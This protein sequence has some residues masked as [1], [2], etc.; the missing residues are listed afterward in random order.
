VKKV[1]RLTKIFMLVLAVALVGSVLALP[2]AASEDV[3]EPIASDDHL[4]PHMSP[5]NSGRGAAL[6]LEGYTHGTDFREA[7]A[8]HGDVRIPRL[9]VPTPDMEIREVAEA[10]ESETT[11][12]PA[13]NTGYASSPVWIFT[14]GALLAAALLIPGRKATHRAE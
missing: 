10:N 8:L 11:F 9:E 14:A 13:P 3:Q 2:A 1:K 7:P 5:P 6:Q 4:I 12:T